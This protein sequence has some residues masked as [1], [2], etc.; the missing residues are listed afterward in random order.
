MANRTAR[1]CLAASVPG[2]DGGR[3]GGLNRSRRPD[4]DGGIRGEEH[5]V[6]DLD[7]KRLVGCFSRWRQDH[8]VGEAG[9]T[10]EGAGQ[11]AETRLRRRLPGARILLSPQDSSDS[12]AQW[13]ASAHIEAD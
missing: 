5:F 10:G 2:H 6:H 9:L 12:H 3:T 13:V 11:G 4:Q 7:G 1:R 8:E